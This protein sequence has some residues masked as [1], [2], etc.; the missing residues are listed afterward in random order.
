MQVGRLSGKQNHP[1]EP[2]SVN[3]DLLGCS[4]T[5]APEPSSSIRLMSDLA[6]LDAD[7]DKTDA[8]E[9]EFSHLD[10]DPS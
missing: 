4:M 9:D 5:S 8:W 7:G 10:F 1:T 3:M 6:P 2:G